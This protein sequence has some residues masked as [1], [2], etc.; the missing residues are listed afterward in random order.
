MLRCKTWGVSAFGNVAY[1]GPFDSTDLITFGQGVQGPVRLSRFVL[2]GRVGQLFRVS[3]S[4]PSI[5]HD[6]GPSPNAVG[7]ERE[8]DRW[9]E[10]G[11]R[12]THCVK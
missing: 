7:I 11:S 5:G 1:A 10:D 9:D 8:C 12:E 6:F 2:V 3:A 4:S